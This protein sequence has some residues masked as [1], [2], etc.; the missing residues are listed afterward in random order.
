MC[1]LQYKKNLK[2]KINFN[3]FIFLISAFAVKI[4]YIFIFEINLLFFNVFVFNFAILNGL[5][6]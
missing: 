4:S 2:T 3:N 1:I 5:V 6:P